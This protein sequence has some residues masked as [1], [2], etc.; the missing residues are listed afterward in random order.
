[1]MFPSP[2]SDQI[3]PIHDVL[4][5][6]AGPCSLAVVA[7]L[8]EHKPSALY[9]DEEHRRFHWLA[10]HASKS[11]VKDRKKG[12][13]HRQGSDTADRRPMSSNDERSILVLDAE[14]KGWMTRW[15]RLFAAF[16]I[17]H[18][19]SPMF[20]HVDPG[21]KDALLAFAYERGREGELKEITGVVGKEVSKHKVKK[22][23]RLAGR[24]G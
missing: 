7:R 19:R 4:I 17:Q 10:K 9:T 6:G 12:K 15:H 3:P 16:E 18:L 21:D 2:P 1:M 11:A 13:V 23:R 24:C 20:F 8:G 14:G 22:R 5:I